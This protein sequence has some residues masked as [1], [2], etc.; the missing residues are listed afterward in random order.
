MAGTS[1]RIVVGV[2]GSPCSRAAL[3]WA[4][5]Q[6]RLDGASVDAVMAWEYPAM[7]SPVAGPAAGYEADIGAEAGK[8]I[9]GIV[10]QEG[11]A[12]AGVPVRPVAAE[13]Q[14]AQVLLDAA[15][16][17]DLLVVGSRGHGGFA[18]MVI[19]SVSLQC[20]LHARCPVLVLRGGHEGDGRA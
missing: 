13:G 10:T 2:D 3:R 14:P 11:G 4:V 7:F 16:G 15:S 18:S 17:A 20:V 5:Q 6:A 12:G 8:A 9:A 1:G 19:G